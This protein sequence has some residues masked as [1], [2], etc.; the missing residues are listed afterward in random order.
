MEHSA[1]ECIER[2][3]ETLILGTSSYLLMPVTFTTVL[4]RFKDQGEKTGWTYINMPATVSEQLLP[5]NKKAFRVKGKM[6]AHAFQLVAAIPMGDGSFIIPFNAAMRKGTG[7]KYG[8]PLLVEIEV[9]TSP[10]PIS[11][12]LLNCLAEDQT[13]LERFNSLAKG[14]KNYFSNWVESA[15]TIGTKSDRI[16]KTLFAMQNQMD[17]GQMIRHFKKSAGRGG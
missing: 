17:Y 2:S 3:P 12:D 4:H 7:K 10:M 16:A 1:L 14:H 13:A 15:K 9:D 11:E 8:D 6:D 5:G